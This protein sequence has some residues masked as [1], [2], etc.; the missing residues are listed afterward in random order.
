V[1][2]GVDSHGGHAVDIFG[3]RINCAPKHCCPLTGTVPKKC[4]DPK[5]IKKADGCKYK[6]SLCFTIK[7]KHNKLQSWPISCVCNFIRWED[8]DVTTCIRGCIQC[9]VDSTNK[10]PNQN[11]HDECI[12]SCIEKYTGPFTSGA[13]VK[14]II[15]ALLTQ[16]INECIEKFSPNGSDYPGFLIPPPEVDCVDGKLIS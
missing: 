12:D 10:T 5:K 15:A 2:N 11:A 8:D 6:D 7:D 4:L 16:A 13:L 14:V 1:P 3:N 9:I